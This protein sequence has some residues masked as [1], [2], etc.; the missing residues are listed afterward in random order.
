MPDWEFIPIYFLMITKLVFGYCS[1]RCFRK[2]LLLILFP[3]TSTVQSLHVLYIV[4]QAKSTSRCQFRF[5]PT[6]PSPAASLILDA[7]CAACASVPA[8]YELR[9]QDTH[10]RLVASPAED[11]ATAK[12]ACQADGAHLAYF[13][14]AQEEDNMWHYANGTCYCLLRTVTTN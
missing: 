13:R 2:I 4:K 3:S 7:A 5:F 1:R 11:F 9:G 14:N 10:Y 6:P 12:A 8:G